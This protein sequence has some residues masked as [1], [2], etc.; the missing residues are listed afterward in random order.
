MKDVNNIDKNHKFGVQ[1][2]AINSQIDNGFD[3]IDKT[4]MLPERVT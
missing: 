3:Q 4:K 2:S 1:L